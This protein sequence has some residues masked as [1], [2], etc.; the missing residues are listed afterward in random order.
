MSI[1]RIAA[2][3]ASASGTLEPMTSSV[4]TEVAAVEME[5][6]SASYDTSVIVADGP[7]PSRCTRSVTS[8]PQVGLMWCT[9]AA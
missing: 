9:C 5:H 8:S 6:P 1:A 4:S 7:L 2:N 3:D